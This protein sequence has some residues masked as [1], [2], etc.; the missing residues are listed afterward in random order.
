MEQ[1]KTGKG[2]LRASYITSIISITMVLFMLGLLGLIII[3]GKKFSNIVK[4]NISVSVYLQKNTTEAE[5][6]Q[7]TKS[8]S[9]KPYIKSAN[10]ISKED[11]AA[12]LSSELGEDFVD[13]LGYNPLPQSIDLS[14]KAQYANSDSITKIEAS[15]LKNRA[16]KEVI[17]QKSLLDQV[18]SNIKRL[19]LIFLG[20][21]IVLLLISITLINNTIKLTIYSKRFLIRSMQLVG[22]TEHFVRKPFVKQGIVHGIIASILGLLLIFATMWLLIKKIPE[23]ANLT[24]TNEYLVF[25]III[26]L[27]GLIISTLSTWFSVN[28]F[29]RMRLDK[30]YNS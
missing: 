8:F 16:V 19:T 7:L 14:I 26:I 15:L 18:N 28:K 27:F 5:A 20:F 25:S 22:A 6:Q 12:S 10:Y 17:Y 1:Q 3:H 30:L 29:L 21:S 24:T 4:E 23:L 9:E 11:A 13:F 2:R